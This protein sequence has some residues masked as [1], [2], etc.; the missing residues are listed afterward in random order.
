MGVWQCRR[1]DAIYPVILID[2]IMVKS[3]TGRSVTGRFT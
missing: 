3:V 1:L 2:A